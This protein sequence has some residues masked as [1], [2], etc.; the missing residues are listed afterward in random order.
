MCPSPFLWEKK[1]KVSQILS[2][3]LTYRKIADSVTAFWI[4][5]AE[6]WL[7]WVQSLLDSTFVVRRACRL[8]QHLLWWKSRLMSRSEVMQNQTVPVLASWC[9]MKVTAGTSTYQNYGHVLLTT[10]LTQPATADVPD[11]L[12]GEMQYVNCPTHHNIKCSIKKLEGMQYAA[13]QNLNSDLI[14]VFIYGFGYPKTI[15]SSFWMKVAL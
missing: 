9:H 13:Q 12:S 14:V 6:R 11:L 3:H 1:V 2:S 10:L 5:L 8:Q 4:A 7:T 15:W